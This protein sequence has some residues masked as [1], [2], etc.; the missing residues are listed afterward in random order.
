MSSKFIIICSRVDRVYEGSRQQ[1]HYNG[2]LFILAPFLPS[3]A[4]TDA[5]HMQC[6][7]FSSFIELRSLNKLFQFCFQSGTIHKYTHTHTSYTVDNI[8]DAVQH[9]WIFSKVVRICNRHV[10]VCVCAQLHRIEYD[11]FRV[12]RIKSKL[13]MK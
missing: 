13:S 12:I 9:N 8:L 6:I 2:C 5:V 7:S 4:E 1:P 11:R 10:C 3:V